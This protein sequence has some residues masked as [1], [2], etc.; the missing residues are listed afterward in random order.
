VQVLAMGQRRIMNASLL[1]LAGAAALAA[2][3]RAP[4]IAVG[5]I[6][7]ESNTFSENLTGLDDFRSAG[8][9]RGDEIEQEYAHSAHEVGGYFEGA[10]KFGLE[11]VPTIVASATPAGPVTDEALDNLTAELIER[12]Q[13]AA[14]LDGLLLALHGAMVTESYPDGD[15]EVLRRLRQALGDELPI[16]VTHDAHANVAPEEV[17]LSTALVIY[18]EVPHIDQRE[19][20]VQAAGIMARIVKEGVRPAQAIEKPPL[21]YNILYHNTKRE[22]MLPLVEEARR[23][24][25]EN[26]KILAVSVPV[27]YQY[28]DVPQMGPS[29]VVVTD[30]DLDL[31][32]SEA[33]RLAALMWE[34]RHV[35]KLDL[36]DAREAVRRAMAA[37]KTPVVLVEMGDNI[38]GGS[39][40]DSTFV[41]R[42]LVEQK[43][44]G[45]VAAI[46]DPE[47][48]QEAVR[49]G[50]G[51]SFDL[52]VGGKTDKMHGEP[53]RI[54]G[55]V[56]LLYD[57]AYVETA[58]RHGGRRYLDQGLTAV[59]HAA[60]STAEL[61]NVVLLNSKRHTPFSLGQLSSA[62]VVPE[63]QK[64]LV[65]K[66]A[67]AFRAA[68]EPI[69][70][71]IIEV[72]TAG[73]TAVNPKRF[74]YKRARPDLFGLR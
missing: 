20:G 23:L 54:R 29:I 13:K 25:R 39:A 44:Q 15:A 26:P 3:S 9:R 70:G 57:G 33:K 43:A 67:V 1:L 72:D 32:K 38:G 47:A 68:Y 10:R 5:G 61:P 66:A 48:V 71:T 31:A 62:G 59:I 14:P 49:V 64:I 37:E 7:H 2:Q 51:G 11:L 52:A 27:G 63:R 19:R 45:Y 21:L 60:G 69:A 53:L 42:E 35:M 40:G 17:R 73:L 50:I 22:P 28:A 55:R 58:V 34:H 36:P 65:V 8:I 46:Y 74:T 16:V 6:L 4:R 18:K 56:K 12:I 24:E 30:G 41:L